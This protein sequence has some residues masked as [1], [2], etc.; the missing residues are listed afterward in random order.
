M[1]GK[2]GTSGQLV[3]H[4]PEKF[5]SYRHEAEQP[6]SRACYSRCPVAREV[7]VVVPTTG[8]VRVHDR[9]L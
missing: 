2:P 8:R 9:R 6:G 7:P 4:K 3:L 1:N 5:I